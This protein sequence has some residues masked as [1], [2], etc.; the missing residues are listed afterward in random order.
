MIIAC[1]A[2]AL[3]FRVRVALL[4]LLLAALLVLLIPLLLVLLARL[5]VLLLTL[6]F[7][8]CL[9]GIAVLLV[10]HDCTL[11]EMPWGMRCVVRRTHSV[12]EKRLIA[13]EKAVSLHVDADDWGTRL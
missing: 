3:L 13:G 8:R 6:L 5:L 4:V 10:S 9:A 2:S 1:N 12:R 11:L 7:L